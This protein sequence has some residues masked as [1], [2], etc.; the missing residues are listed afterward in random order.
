MGMGEAW[1]E[2]GDSFEDPITWAELAWYAIAFGALGLWYW[3]S[4]RR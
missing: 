2:L 3:F 1:L 4:G